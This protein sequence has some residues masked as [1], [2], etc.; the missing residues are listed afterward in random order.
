MH[1][2]DEAAIASGIVPI[3]PQML[4]RGSATRLPQMPRLE[5]TPR[6]RAIILSY[7]RLQFTHRKISQLTTIPKSTVADII[8]RAKD[9]IAQGLSATGNYPRTGRP[10]QLPVEVSQE[11]MQAVEDNPFIT[12][13]EI[14]TWVLS[15]LNLKAPRTYIEKVLHNH[16]YISTVARR[17]PFLTKDHMAKRLEWCLERKDWTLEEW[18]RIIWT[19]ESSFELGGGGSQRRVRKYRI[20]VLT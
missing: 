3:A 19:D 14:S 4:W 9:R 13:N 20:Y 18:R 8:Q 7:S 15:V 5:T 17:K 2:V 6:T 12:V 1:N 10:S 16:D 11:I